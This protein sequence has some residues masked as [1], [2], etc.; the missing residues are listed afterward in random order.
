MPIDPDSNR[1]IADQ[2]ADSIAPHAVAH[3]REHWDEIVGDV[4]NPVERFALRHSQGTALHL[5]PALSK[6]GAET[7]M[8]ELG[9]LSIVDI[10]RALVSHA[11][12]RGVA[13]HPSMAAVAAGLR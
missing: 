11:R 5:V 2:F 3:L 6:V 4:Q 8:D 12:R 7:A 13:P 1:A 10:A 9:K